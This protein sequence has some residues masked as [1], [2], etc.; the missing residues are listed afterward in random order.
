MMCFAHASMRIVGD[1][2]ASACVAYSRYV[3]G[4]SPEI[5]SRCS[6]LTTMMC[7]HV[8]SVSTIVTR[9]PCLTKHVV[10]V[11]GHSEWSIAWL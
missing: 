11:A 3:Q 4:V 8:L 10:L 9:P 5:R 2:V 7:V 1:G 6:N